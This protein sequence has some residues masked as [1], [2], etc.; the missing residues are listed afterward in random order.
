MCLALPAKVLTLGD[1]MATVSLGGV[2][3]E[4][5]LALVEDVAPGDYVIVHTG[6]ALSRLDPEE[7]QLT[8]KTF[9]DAGFDTGED[10]DADGA[11]N[12]SAETTP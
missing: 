3:M 5:S 11:A 1:G 12:D 7:A 10:A 4:I 8:L 6:Y 9:R 2:K